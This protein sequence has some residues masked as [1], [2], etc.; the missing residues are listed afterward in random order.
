MISVTEAKRAMFSRAPVLSEER[1]PFRDAIGRTL[2]RDVV[3]RHDMPAFASS[4]MDGYGILWQEGE[5]IVGRDFTEV[6][7]VYAGDVISASLR[8]GQTVR[9]MTGAPVPEDIGAVIQKEWAESA[10]GKVRFTRNPTSHKMNIR[11]A[12]EDFPSGVTVMKAGS[13]LGPV[14]LSLLAQFGEVEVAVAAKPRVCVISTGDEIVPAETQRL[15]PGQVRNSNSVYIAESLK[16][17]GCDVQ[18]VGIVG[19]DPAKLKAAFRTALVS[20]IVISSGGVSVGDKDY[21]KAI[22]AEI[23]AKEVFWRIAQKPGKPVFFAA[24]DNSLI[25]G[26]PGN[27]GAVIICMEEYIKPLICRAL[28][29]FSPDPCET[30]ARLLSRVTKKEGLTHFVRS[31][32]EA[33]VEGLTVQPVGAQSSGCIGNMLDANAFLV[34]PPEATELREGDMVIVHVLNGNAAFAAG[35]STV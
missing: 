15:G 33:G 4:A 29:R 26:L 22:W 1:L 17:L 3:A 25:F 32:V 27:P 18:E 19:D 13:V 5:D 7:I 12:G 8:E 16:A 14:E 6:E 10:G 23:G 30:R 9:I 2:R 11:P 35:P 34:A 31:K 21:V 20:D 24:S 28:G